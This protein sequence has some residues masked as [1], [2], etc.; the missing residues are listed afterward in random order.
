[1]LALV[2]FGILIAYFALAAYAGV[3]A[4]RRS[5]PVHEDLKCLG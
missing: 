3:C 4:A 1:M 5:R 2:I